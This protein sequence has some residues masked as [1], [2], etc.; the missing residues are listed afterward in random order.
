MPDIRHGPTLLHGCLRRFCANPPKPDRRL[1]RAFRRFCVMYVRKHYRPIPANSDVSFE[2]W[3]ARTNYP[4]HRKEELRKVWNACPSV[5]PTDLANNSFGKVETYPSFK[6]AR[7]INSRSDRFKCFSGPFFKLM[8][9]EVYDLNREPSF[10]KHVPVRERPGYIRKILGH[11]PGPYYETDYSQ[12]EKHFTPQV[13]ESCEFVLYKHMLRNFPDAY[14]VISGAMRGTNVCRFKQFTIKVQGRRMSGEMCTSLGNGFTNLMLAKFLAYHKTGDPDSLV[15]VV[16]GDD[17]LFAS[18]AP[19]SVSDFKKLGFEIKILKHHNLLRTSFCGIVM[20]E[21]LHTMTDPRDVLLNFG[22][23]SSVLA[24]GGVKSRNGL[25]RAKALSLAYEHPACPIISV[26]AQAVLNDTSRYEP[27]FRGNTYERSLEQEVVKFKDETDR[28]LKAGPTDRTRMDFAH[29]FGV[30][31]ALQHQIETEIR[32]ARG[33]VLAGWGIDALMAGAHA[34]TLTY[35]DR[36]TWHEKVW[37][38]SC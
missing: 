14:R 12:F 13:L 32:N 4:E 19:L 33:G 25:L 22:W 34:D 28:L 15:G 26:L 30:S 35:H 29:H 23:S 37:R 6:P 10:I 38:F 9:D 11:F 27:I 1:L 7:G 5:S 31:V 24:F 3:L 16:E 8:E 21:D 18:R 20:S 2:A 17:G 36:F